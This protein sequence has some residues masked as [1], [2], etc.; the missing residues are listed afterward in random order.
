MMPGPGISVMWHSVCGGAGS[1]GKGGVHHGATVR[2]VRKRNVMRSM[3]NVEPFNGE[4]EK[5]QKS[6]RERKR[7]GLDQPVSGGG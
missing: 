2:Q 5:N 3:A 7:G 4:P 6:G 1:P